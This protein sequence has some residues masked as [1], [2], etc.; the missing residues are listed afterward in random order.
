MAS[1]VGRR[2]A[3]SSIQTNTPSTTRAIRRKTRRTFRTLTVDADRG[4]SE[5]ENTPVVACMGPGIAA[6]L[7]QMG[8]I[9]VSQ[10]LAL[11]PPTTAEGRFRSILRQTGA[12]VVATTASV[13][14]AISMILQREMVHRVVVVLDPGQTEVSVAELTWDGPLDICVPQLESSIASQLPEDP[15]D[16]TWIVYGH[17]ESGL[18]GA[19]WTLGS[20]ASA[21][22][23]VQWLV[24]QHLTPK[25]P[26]FLSNFGPCIMVDRIL[27][28]WALLAGGRVLCGDGMWRTVVDHIIPLQ[29]QI[30]LV[31]PKL[32]RT[33]V[34]LRTFQPEPE[35]SGI[36]PT[37]TSRLFKTE[38]PSAR[39]L[40]RRIGLVFNVESS[41]TNDL[42]MKAI[43]KDVGCPILDVFHS[44][45]V[46]IICTKEFAA[47]GFRLLG[48][49]MPNVE[50]TVF[51]DDNFSD[52]GRLRVFC[53][54]FRGY[55]KP[56]PGDLQEAFLTDDVVLVASGKTAPRL[57]LLDRSRRFQ[58]WAFFVEDDPE[59]RHSGSLWMIQEQAKKSKYILETLVEVS[60]DRTV[61]FLVLPN[62]VT[63][64][65]WARKRNIRLSWTQLVSHDLV[66][67]HYLKIL[68]TLVDRSVPVNHLEVRD[69]NFELGVEVT[70]LGRVIGLRRSFEKTPSVVYSH[71]RQ[72]STLMEDVSL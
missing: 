48:D 10:P 67:Q 60:D 9:A 21:A 31:T 17:G 1:S 12:Q 72:E 8:C 45:E 61:T 7:V 47:G 41:I 46:G 58:D 71:H 56:T 34:N 20:I 15:N 13:L 26:G 49:S 19:V 23:N 51:P 52:I 5:V 30:G 2:I 69:T 54:Y 29:P 59:R 3:E 42:D 36:G 70:H 68:R 4:G 39:V 24:T 40:G 11:V 37:I 53:C 55:F 22:F 65:S 64:S 66:R 50:L 44:R 28:L 16:R 32:L 63:L 43:V 35:A 62:P 25:Q 6:Y 38:S 14:P 57:M 27:G 33:L 18:R